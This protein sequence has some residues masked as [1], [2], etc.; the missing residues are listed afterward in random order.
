MNQP[1][2]NADQFL[3]TA[4]GREWTRILRG[5]GWAGGLLFM[6]GVAHAAGTLTVSTPGYPANRSAEYTM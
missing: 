4:N 2:M 3:L 6:G 5:W 1:Q